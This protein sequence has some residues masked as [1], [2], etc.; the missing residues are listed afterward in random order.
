MWRGGLARLGSGTTNSEAFL[1]SLFFFQ[2]DAT[3]SAID[4][5][6]SHAVLDPGTQ[7]LFDDDDPE[8]DDQADAGDS[9]PA[10]HTVTAAPA[11]RGSDGGFL[12][13]QIST[14][15]SQGLSAVRWRVCDGCLHECGLGGRG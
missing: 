10:R 1:R 11:G 6:G 2:V 3:A 14:T 12:C 13:L 5:G 7:N 4:D 9:V 15:P 8:A